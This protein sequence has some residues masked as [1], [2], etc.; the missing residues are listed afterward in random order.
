MEWNWIWRD[1]KLRVKE[2]KTDFSVKEKWVEQNA[3]RSRKD[4]FEAF[5][6]V[7]EIPKTKDVNQLQGFIIPHLMKV[8]CSKMSKTK[9]SEQKTWTCAESS[10]PGA[11]A[12]PVAHSAS[13]KHSC[14]SACLW[15]V[16][17][18]IF[19][20]DPKKYFRLK[21]KRRPEDEHKG[22]LYPPCDPCIIVSYPSSWSLL[23]LF[24]FLWWA[25]IFHHPGNRYSK[26]N[27]LPV[28]PL[29]VSF[30]AVQHNHARHVVHHLLSWWWW[31]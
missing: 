18:C 1:Q 29:S 3:N 20:V 24:G 10:S 31:W 11:A 21:C 14:L 6:P 8:T 27:V 22:S 12:W 15:I 19:Y 9:R 25:S 16:M 23:S 28:M 2:C 17:D 26:S 4:Y 5:Y 7:G 13:W 30:R